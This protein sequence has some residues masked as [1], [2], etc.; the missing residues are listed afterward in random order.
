MK[1]QKG[2]KGLFCYTFCSTNLKNECIDMYMT[3]KK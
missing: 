3:Y 2:D 1:P